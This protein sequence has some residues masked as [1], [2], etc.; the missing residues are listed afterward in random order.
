MFIKNITVIGMGFI[1]LPTALLLAN[2]KT[3]IN[4]ID[5]DKNKISEL[6]KGNLFIK[7]RD[8][9]NLF[10]KKKKFL[11]FSDKIIKSNTYIVCL[12]TPTKKIDKFFYKQDLKIINKSFFQLEKILKK[13]DLVII[14]ST[15]PPKTALNFYQKINKKIKFHVSTCPERAIPG[16]TIHEMTNNSRIIGSSSNL[17]YKKTRMIY[18]KFVKGKVYRTSL[19]EAELIKLYENTFRDVNIALSTE[20]Q[21]IAEKYNV[22]TKKVFQ[23][24]N[25]HPRVN[26]LKSGIGVGG[27]CIPVDPW[28][29]IKRDKNSIIYN[30]RII[31][32]KQEDKIFNKINKIIGKK[33]NTLLFGVTYKENVDDI[34]N[35]PALNIIKKIRKVNTKVNIF[36]PINDNFNNINIKDLREKKF[37]LLVVF[38]N[39]D[40]L[41]KNSINYKKK[42]I[43]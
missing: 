36:D 18:D 43:L 38:V 5:I 28:F 17:A 29:L 8:I 41:K 19:V 37:D 16:S 39:H 15:C 10:D 2:S 30:S 33:K 34:R 12:P 22:N 27:H 26:F 3:L 42:I 9:K 25:L 31:N 40:W 13:N 35:S 7:E 1:G 32:L 21:K 6:K 20:L 11:R 24:S 4:C 14:E 23:L